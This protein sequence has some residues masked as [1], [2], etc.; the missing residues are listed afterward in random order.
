MIFVLFFVFRELENYKSQLI[1]L[2][3]ILASNQKEANKLKSEL[4]K[5][6]DEIS[7][8]NRVNM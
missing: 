4:K 7:V 3:E 1:E 5:Q 2:R 8:L 6:Q